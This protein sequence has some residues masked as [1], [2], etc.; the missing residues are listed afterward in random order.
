LT[1]KVLQLTVRVLQL[2]V[3]VLQLTV[4]DFIVELQKGNFLP[5]N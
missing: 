3:K 4:K 2:T 1:V 5:S